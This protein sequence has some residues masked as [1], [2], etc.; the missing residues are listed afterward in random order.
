MMLPLTLAIKSLRNRKFTVC[1]T[2]FSIALSVMLLV[3]VERLRH[4]I[5]TSFTNTIS[6]TDLIVGARSGSIPLLLYSVFRIGNPTQNISY[7][8]FEKISSNA[9][10]A[11]TIPISLGDSHR[12]YRVMGTTEMFFEHYHY[13]N[14]RDIRFADGEGF[15][16]PYAAVLGSEVADML[17]Y[18]V[19]DE[20]IIA[21]GTGDVS[22]VEHDDK[23]FQVSGVLKPTGTPVDRTVLVSLEGITAMHLGFGHE[24]DHEGHSHHHE[25]SAGEALLEDLTPTQIT[26]F[27]VGMKSRADALFMQRRINTSQ[28]EPLTAILPGVALQELWGVVGIAEKTLMLV[29]G[30]V[31]IVALTGMLTVLMTSLNERRREMAILRSVGARP[32]HVFALIIGEALGT[33]V[34]AVASGMV[35]VYGAIMAGGPLVES[36]FGIY[37]P[38]SAPSLREWVLL[39]IIV[40]AGMLIGLIPGYRS[41]R[42]SLADGLTVKV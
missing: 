42:Y 21:H 15:D 18:E 31:L 19:S 39:G 5:R 11:W 38:V 17:G 6:G 7:E 28:E 35:L 1:L 26:A 20:V 4:E 41:Y 10:V 8:S 23:P 32:I 13:A 37:L 16:S 9:G 3:G 30:C 2:V 24:E 40:A 36:K 25:L 12:G 14:G 22:F 29:S 27:M 34:A 33:T